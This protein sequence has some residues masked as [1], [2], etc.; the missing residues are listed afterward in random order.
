MARTSWDMLTTGAALPRWA[1]R[2]PVA[3]LATVDGTRPHIVPVVFCVCDGAL[4]VPVDGKPKSG[5][6]LR[7][8]ENIERNPAVSLLI[9]EYQDDWTRLRWLRA[10]G[11]AAGVPTSAPVRAALQAKYPQYRE[12]PVGSRA[13]R[14]AVTRVRSWSATD[15][16]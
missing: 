13:I 14:I 5:R 9:D 1:A 12:T 10:D 4:F 7:R 6:K 2:A 16:A 8:V 3:R 15:T 11:T